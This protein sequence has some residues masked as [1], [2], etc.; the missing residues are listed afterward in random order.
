MSDAKMNH[1]LLWRLGQSG[2]LLLLVKQRLT[3]LVLGWVTHGSCKGADV[4]LAR[5]TTLVAACLTSSRE[6]ALPC[7]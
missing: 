6:T 4:G 7:L 5:F 3:W 1:W 2:G